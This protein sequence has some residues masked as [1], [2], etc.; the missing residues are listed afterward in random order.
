MYLHEYMPINKS[1][2]NNIQA[3]VRTPLSCVRQPRRMHVRACLTGACMT[4]NVC[5]RPFR[6]QTKQMGGLL[7]NPQTGTSYFEIDALL[8]YDP[9]MYLAIDDLDKGEV[10]EPFEFTDRYGR[11]GYRILYVQ[12]QRDAHRMNLEYDFDVIKDRALERKKNE[13]LYQWLENATSDVFIAVNDQYRSCPNM[14]IWLKA[15]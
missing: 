4:L 14:P 13:V 11:T 7:F 9:D 15:K 10:S 8:E 3:H 12:N 1:E 6:F 5:I 2:T